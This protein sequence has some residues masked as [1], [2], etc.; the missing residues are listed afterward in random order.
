MSERDKD[1]KQGPAPVTSSGTE[2]PAPGRSSV[3]SRYGQGG[4]APAGP[5]APAA[6]AA[7]PSA[8][9]PPPPPPQ[10]D[11]DRDA[12]PSAS[13]DS[14]FELGGESPVPRAR[15]DRESEVKEDARPRWLQNKPAPGSGG[16]AAAPGI[17]DEAVPGSDTEDEDRDD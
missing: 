2:R 16:G 10:D 14:A 15:S 5:A 12:G 7:A 9:P 13:F 17:A 1:A 4:A 3:R 6:P 11:G 8:P